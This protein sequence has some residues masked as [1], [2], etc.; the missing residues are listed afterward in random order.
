MPAY[1]GAAGAAFL[2]RTPGRESLTLQHDDGIVTVRQG[3][4]YITV[5]LFERPTGDHLR[6]ESWRVLLEALDVHAVTG[7]EALG[8]ERGDGEYLTWIRDEEERY[9][10]TIASTASLPWSMKGTATSTPPPGA[11][12][13]TRTRQPARPVPH[14]PSFRFWRL[15]RLADDLFDAYRN[16]FLALECLVSDASPKQP[17]ESELN[18]IK[19]V[20]RDPLSAGLP[21]GMDVDATVEELYKVGRLPLFHAKMGKGFYAPQGEERERVELLLGRLNFLLTCLYGRRF[22]F[23]SGWGRLAADTK[24]AQARAVFQFDEVIYTNGGEHVSRKPR[25]EVMEEPRRFGNLWARI[26][27]APPSKLPYVDK[28]ELRNRE[29]ERGTLEFDE[30]VPMS[31][32]NTVNIEIQLLIY[33]VRAPRPSRPM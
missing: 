2:L 8:T 1:N 13:A 15:S 23:G 9:R 20:L 10:L 4:P 3:A 27:V 22:G 7:R 19:R 16:A 24:D 31:A 30:L 29:D 17:R 5:Q 26:Q 32:V 11:Q 12:D 25:V 18:W 28:I 14:H 6:T 21:P 33:N